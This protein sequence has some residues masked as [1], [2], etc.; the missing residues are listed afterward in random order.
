MTKEKVLARVGAFFVNPND[1]CP[2]WARIS[3]RN[4]RESLSVLSK[5]TR[6]RSK[7]LNL[8]A[9]SI[10][11]IEHVELHRNKDKN[12]ALDQRN[13]QQL[14]RVVSKCSI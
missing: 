9:C 5:N 12:S 7:Y 11:E 6:R 2:V 13:N 3:V 14:K 4:Q 1:C 8:I 10:L